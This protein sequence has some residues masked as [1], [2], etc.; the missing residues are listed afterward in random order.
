MNDFFVTKVIII[1]QIKYFIST[2]KYSTINFD[3]L[4]I[5]LN[6]LIHSFISK[7]CMI[8]YYDMISYNVFNINS[9]QTKNV[10]YSKPKSPT[11]KSH[12]FPLNPIPF[13]FHNKPNNP[14]PLRH[15]H[16]IPS[17]IQQRTNLSHILFL[18]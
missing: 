3:C 1:L 2:W 11:R 12:S 14:S 8:H 18:L 13:P 17:I 6:I 5:N 9:I 4:N 10:I 7:L 15:L 16:L